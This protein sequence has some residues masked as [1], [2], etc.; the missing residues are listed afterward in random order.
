MDRLVPTGCFLSDWHLLAVED[1][2]HS[3]AGSDIQGYFRAVSPVC[4][5][6]LSAVSWKLR[7]VGL[8]LGTME[9]VLTIKWRCHVP[10]NH[11][12]TVSCLST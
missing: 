7:P 4:R 8:M 11:S 1:I 5:S 10:H 2:C 6:S 12:G 9:G 3:K